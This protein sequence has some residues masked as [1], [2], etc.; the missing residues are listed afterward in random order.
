M[1]GVNVIHKY[2]GRG[3]LGVHGTQGNYEDYCYS[4]KRRDVVR[5]FIVT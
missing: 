5:Q 1:K 4:R 3:L 2:V